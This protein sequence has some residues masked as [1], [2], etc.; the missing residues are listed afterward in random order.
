[1]EYNAPSFVELCLCELFIHTAKQY[2]A[3]EYAN[4][5][6]H[7]IPRTMV[8]ELNFA[9]ASN[10]EFPSYQMIINIIVSQHADQL[11]VHCVVWIISEISV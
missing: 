6:P 8:C 10:T 1:M 9:V 4:A 3:T 2:F 7:E 11:I 5:N